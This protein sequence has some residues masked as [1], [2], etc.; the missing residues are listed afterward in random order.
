M[1]ETSA[2]LVIYRHFYFC[3]RFEW[4]ATVE[5]TGSDENIVDI[6]NT[7]LVSFDVGVAKRYI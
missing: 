6:E 1:W 3:K 2:V 4:A 5:G 7:M